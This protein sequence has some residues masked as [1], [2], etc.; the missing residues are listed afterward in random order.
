MSV[1]RKGERWERKNDSSVCRIMADPIE[2][3][4]MARFKGAMP[5]LVH[6]SEWHRHFRIYHPTAKG[7]TDGE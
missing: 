1:P 2:G 5:F 3:Y 4:V 7:A 6:V